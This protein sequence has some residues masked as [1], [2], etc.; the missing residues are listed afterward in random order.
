MGNVM[1]LDASVLIAYLDSDDRH[2]AAAETLLAREI[3]DDVA[4]THSRSL[5]C[6]LGRHGRA[7][8]TRHCPFSS[9]SRSKHWSFPRK[10]QFVLLGYVP[11]PVSRCLAVVFCCPPKKR[12]LAS[13]LR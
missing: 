4:V 5:R 1:V 12:P 13:R 6:S 10:L 11:L 2:H 3:D 7:F 9:L 8:W